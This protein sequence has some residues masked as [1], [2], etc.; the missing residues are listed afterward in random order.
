MI[1]RHLHLAQD[2]EKLAA[3]TLIDTPPPVFLDLNGE[4]LGYQY[5]WEVPVLA[6]GLIIN[7]Y[8]AHTEGP[9]YTPIS[10]SDFDSERVQSVL[11][12]SLNEVFTP[13]LVN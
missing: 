13:Q 4:D 3:T 2:L 6:Q 11:S 10:P 1:I 9:A 7:K 8:L 5:I 12:L